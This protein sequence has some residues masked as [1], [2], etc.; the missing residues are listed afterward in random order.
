MTDQPTTDAAEQAGYAAVWTRFH[1]GSRVTVIL[2][3]LNGDTTARINAWMWRNVQAATRAALA[4]ERA[5]VGVGL[6]EDAPPAPQDEPGGANTPQVVAREGRNALRGS[7]A[8]PEAVRM[9]ARDAANEH[10]IKA[11]GQVTVTDLIDAAITATWQAGHRLYA[12][13]RWLPAADRID[14]LDDLRARADRLWLGW[15]RTM[16]AARAFAEDRLDAPELAG[17]TITDPAQRSVAV[18]ALRD[19][20]QALAETV[21]WILN[22]GQPCPWYLGWRQRSDRARSVLAELTTPEADRG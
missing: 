15:E 2:P 4:A 11:D 21:N 18:E 9:V 20:T 16:R 22:S 1:A 8:V 13:P 6:D 19:A 14:T 7:E 3:S 17:A 12:H 10:A 5:T